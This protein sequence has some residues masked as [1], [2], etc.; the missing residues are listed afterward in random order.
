VTRE[1]RLDSD[2]LTITGDM[3]IGGRLYTDINLAIAGDWTTFSGTAVNP[4]GKTVYADTT[5]AGDEN[6]FIESGNY[7][8]TSVINFD[9]G[10]STSIS[11]GLGVYGTLALDKNNNW[12]YSLDNSDPDTIAL[13]EGQSVMDLFTVSVSDGTDD[14]TQHILINVIG[15]SAVFKI[16]T[17]DPSASNNLP[18][19]NITLDIYKDG[20]DTY[21]DLIIDNGEFRKNEN[22]SFDSVKLSD[23]TTYDFDINISDAIDVLRHIVDLE[24][25]TEGSYAYHAADVN[26]DGNIAISDAIDI[27]R[28][29]VD[30]EAIDTFDLIDSDGNRVTQL[31]AN[32]SGEVPIWTLV[33]NGDVDM[34]GSFADDYVIAS[35]LV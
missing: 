30:L 18:L 35:D 26:N 29:I 10:L 1:G 16:H 34:S 9:S 11:G 27:L 21:K 6:V 7:G 24:V 15:R 22:I 25:L 13:I 32:A 20:N 31:D 3:V 2:P 5:D 19:H 14:V 4:V 8:I 23:A 12:F 17:P 28:H 33:A